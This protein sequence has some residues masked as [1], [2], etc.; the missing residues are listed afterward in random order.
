MKSK[1]SILSGAIS[2]GKSSRQIPVVVP[3]GVAINGSVNPGEFAIT[4]TG[5]LFYVLSTSA[6]ITLQPVR[7]G[8]I[9]NANIFSTGQG[10]PVS[11]GFDTLTV[12]NFSLFPIVCLIWVGYDSFINDQLYLVNSAYSQVAN[13]TYP[14]ANAAAVVNIPD[15]SGQ[16]FFDINGKKWGALS[17]VA[18]LVFNTD[19][20]VSVTLQKA[21]ALTATGPAVGLIYPL[22]PVR[23]DIAGDYCLCNGGGNVNC[24]VSEI[25]NAIAL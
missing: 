17:R 24:I 23:F 14:L 8:S 25:Y 6:P 4:Q 12:K 22:T 16:S 1:N 18:I 5:N 13:P 2:T 21:G 20:G 7:A 9:G 10:Q 11:D 19:S 3:A 15:L